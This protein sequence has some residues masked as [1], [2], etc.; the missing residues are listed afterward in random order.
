MVFVGYMGHDT[1]F[2]GQSISRN[3]KEKVKGYSWEMVIDRLEEVHASLNTPAFKINETGNRGTIV[4]LGKPLVREKL[5][6]IVI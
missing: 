3:N 1:H 4:N 5:S 6:R 2:R